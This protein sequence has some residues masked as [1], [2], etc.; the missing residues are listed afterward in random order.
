MGLFDNRKTKLSSEIFLPI[1]QI[2][3]SVQETILE[4]LLNI[5]P[6]QLLH[7]VWIVGS[8]LGNYYDDGS[9][10]DVQVQLV[11]KSK[12]DYYSNEMK[13]FNRSGQN[14]LVGKHP[15]NF[16]VLPKIETTNYDNL[17]GAYDLIN[18]KWI[19][20]A[21]NPPQGFEQRLTIERPYL[22]ML[23]REMARQVEQ[24]KKDPSIQ[25][26]KDIA[27]LYERL[28]KE[29]KLAYNFGL[30][31]PKYTPANIQYK[32]IESEYKEI[33]EKIYHL[34]KRMTEKNG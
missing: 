31:V 27:D 3:P 7:S 28:D 29:R 5:I 17:T 32:A 25:Q 23:K 15:V 26:A 18:M 2:K 6:I 33:P 14:H 34:I 30:G 16:F 22:G 13:V 20:R 9:D 10:I 12:V 24:A 4:S 21:V 8:M 11:D 1:E 19:K